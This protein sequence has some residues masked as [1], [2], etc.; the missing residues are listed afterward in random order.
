MAGIDFDFSEVD[1]LAADLLAAPLKAAPKILTAL[2]VT[3]RH[4]KDDWRESVSGAKFV[5]GGAA[6]ISYDIDGAS[7]TDMRAEIGPELV[8]QGPLVG[9]LE[10]GTPN[11]GPRQ[12]GR[13][14]LAKNEA[15][16][17]KGILIATE[18]VL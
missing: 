8:G 4:V 18:G 9:M 6:A 7:L 1:R 17:V 10:D 11:T 5:G 15:D 14:A 2:E 3:A 12:W 16:F 13:S